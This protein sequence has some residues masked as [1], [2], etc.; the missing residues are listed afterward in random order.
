MINGDEKYDITSELKHRLT[1]LRP[2]T[3][4]S[5]RAVALPVGAGTDVYE[6][7]GAPTDQIMFKTPGDSPSAP[8]LNV[9]LESQTSTVS[10][11]HLFS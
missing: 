11:M 8:P 5:I 6:A 1:D 9:T 2:F 4:Y 3:E 7:A 10:E